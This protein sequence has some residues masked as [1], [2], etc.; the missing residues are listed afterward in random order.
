VTVTRKTKP[1]SARR[2]DVVRLASQLFAQKGYRATTVRE[3]ADAAGILS[4]SLYHHFDSKESIGDEI[5][6]SFLDQLR[7]DYRAA[8]SSGGDPRSVLEQIVRTTSKTLAK[9][10]A[11]LTMLRNDWGYFN[12]H[13]RFEY[14]PKT[15]REFEQTWISQ[16]E[17]G[18]AEG[19]F[20]ADLDPGL[21]YRLLRDVLW[22]PAAWHR[23]G[24]YTTDQ[25]VDAFLA[26]LFDGITAES[27]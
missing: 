24:G 3:I 10:R 13:P 17:R 9:N 21:T 5:L 27:P 1:E 16:L 25:V 22:I 6:A 15:L 4:G 19:T 7:A 2:D 14:L 23:S 18:V 20:R 11:A 26:L 8:I 12:S